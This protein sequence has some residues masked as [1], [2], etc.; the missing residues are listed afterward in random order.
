[1]I[2]TVNMI[3]YRDRYIITDEMIHFS[4]PDT[5]LI[6]IESKTVLVTE[7][8]AAPLT[9]NLPR[10]EAEKITEYEN[11]ALEINLVPSIPLC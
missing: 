5:V 1:V 6:D 11:L 9:C 7:T 2:E 3:L 10:T 4:K 8:A